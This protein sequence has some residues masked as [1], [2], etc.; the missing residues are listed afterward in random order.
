MKLLSQNVGV[1]C[2]FVAGLQLNLYR[3]LCM[4]YAMI[5][6][7]SSEY[8]ILTKPVL[9]ITLLGYVMCIE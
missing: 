8:A 1:S 3:V 6:K 7:Y 2:L 4:R 5:N 9:G